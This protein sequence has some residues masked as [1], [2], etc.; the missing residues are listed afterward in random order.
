MIRVVCRIGLRSI[1][2]TRQNQLQ[3]LQPVVKQI[4]APPEQ[5]VNAYLNWCGASGHYHGVLSPSLSPTLPPHMVSQWGLPLVAEL[6]FKT[7]FPLTKVLNQGITLDVHGELPRNQPLLCQA[8]VKSII[9]DDY[10]TRI[11]VVIQTGTVPQPNLVEATL[12]MVFINKKVPKTKREV[13][14]ATEPD[15]QEHGTWRASDHDGLLF[16]LITGDFN[17]IHWLTLAGKLSA[18]NKK[19]LHGFGTFARTYELLNPKQIARIDVRFLRPVPLPSGELV[20]EQST[21]Q[22]DNTVQIRLRDAEH[23]LH[24]VGTATLR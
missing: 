17:P 1:A 10:R 7:P 9:D 6:L 19:I 24:L 13:S 16:S 8:Y 3:S 11:S 14:A 15:W 4:P 18:L 22:V 20:V 2:P 12:H 5:L 23:Q 21:Q